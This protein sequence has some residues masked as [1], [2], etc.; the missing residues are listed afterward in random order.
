MKIQSGKVRHIAFFTEEAM[1][2]PS[3]TL[4]VMGESPILSIPEG[5]TNGQIEC[6][7]TTLNGAHF[8]VFRFDVWENQSA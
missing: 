6:S 5:Y 8:A 4:A 2:H 3:F 1:K 7:W